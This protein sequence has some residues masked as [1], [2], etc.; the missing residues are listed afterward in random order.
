[1]EHLQT[2]SNALS[3]GNSA[4]EINIAAASFGVSCSCMCVFFITVLHLTTVESNGNINSD[5]KRTHQDHAR[6]WG[7]SY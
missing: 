5:I 4:Y 6:I 1:M 7:C 3:E 2:L